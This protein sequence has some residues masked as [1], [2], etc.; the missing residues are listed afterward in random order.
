M[1]AN[2]VHEGTYATNKEAS[3]SFN[4]SDGENSAEANAL[5]EEQEYINQLNKTKEN[6]L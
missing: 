3:S 6:G 1:G 4:K 2:G 5:K